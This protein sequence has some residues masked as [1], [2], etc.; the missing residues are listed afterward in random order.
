MQ[1]IYL[2]KSIRIYQ[3][4]KNFLIFLPTILAHEFV[5]F[6]LLLPFFLLCLVTSC[7]YLIND[8]KDK[9]KDINHPRKSKRP[10]ASNL[11]NNNYISLFIFT[12]LLAII[13]YSFY[14][15][16]YIIVILLLL[17]LLVTS[18]YSF[19][20][21]NFKYLDILCLSI[22]FCYRIIYGGILGETIISIY[23]LFFSLLFFISLALSKRLNEVQNIRNEKTLSNIGRPYKL[24]DSKNIFYLTVISNLLS[25]FIFL[26]YFF[27]E[28]FKKLYEMNYL[29]FIAIFL[30]FLWLL[31]M[32][33]YANKGYLDDDP[34][35]YAIKDKLS[36]VFG[37]IIII[38]FYLSAL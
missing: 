8:L 7:V 14:F 24:N 25:I 27:S 33:L 37:F 12:T 21:K 6:P 13:F 16:D 31:R 1:I 18:L 10:I 2:I 32:N 20:L 3:W 5:L 26:N 23:L 17:Y 28:Q 30:L 35:M 15:N 19:Y 11:L 29:V 38:M 34:I 9:N 36:Y 22:L 4:S